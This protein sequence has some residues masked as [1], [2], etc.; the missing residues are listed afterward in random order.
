MSARKTKKWERDLLHVNEWVD[1]T[2]EDFNLRLRARESIP[3]KLP[4][5]T[6]GGHMLLTFDQ[7]FNNDIY[8]ECVL[9]AQSA[10]RLK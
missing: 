9:A 3:I 5:L 1:V 4:E 10:W 7:M 2:L 6:W 8:G